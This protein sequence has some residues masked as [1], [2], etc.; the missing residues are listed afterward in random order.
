[1]QGVLDFLKVRMPSS[2]PEQ[3]QALACKFEMTIWTEADSYDD[4]ASRIKRRLDRVQV[5]NS[6]AASG[7]ENGAADWRSA[8]VT[9]PQSQATMPPSASMQPQHSGHS[10]S[11]EQPS[12]GHRPPPSADATPPPANIATTAIASSAVAAGAV[13]RP[14]PRSA[15]AAMSAPP[16]PPPR[17][18]PLQLPPPPT[19]T[20]H[21]PMMA[22]ADARDGGGGRVSPYAP[23]TPTVRPGGGAHAAAAWS[24]PPLTPPP[25]SAP[26]PGPMRRPP[27][28]AAQYAQLVKRLRDGEQ[29]RRG[30]YKDF[31]QALRR[32]EEA[33]EGRARRVRELRA[34]VEEYLE[35]LRERPGETPRGVADILRLNELHA[36]ISHEVLGRSATR[37]EGKEGKEGGAAGAT[38]ATGGAG[39]ARSAIDAA[40]ADG[41][42][43]GGGGSSAGAVGGAVGGAGGRT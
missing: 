23:G 14:V 5:P 15:A 6:S 41:A 31:L 16:P 43:A 13:A 39:G 21:A 29:A 12:L 34:V 8:R 40:A 4:Y 1:M 33:D 7:K 27:H 18:H 24:P 2:T 37:K 38:S 26:T 10:A 9:T 20:S 28:A 42:G 25:R 30:F 36:V 22:S 3:V 35:R 11:R 17:P 19:Q 32:A